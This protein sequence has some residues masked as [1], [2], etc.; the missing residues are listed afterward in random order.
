MLLRR[1]S[2][3]A[4]TWVNGVTPVSPV[5]IIV[6]LVATTS[7]LAIGSYLLLKSRAS[8]RKLKAE[9]ADQ[10][11]SAKAAEAANRAKAE[12]LTSMS[13]QIRTPLNAIM[14]FTDLAL[15]SELKPELRDYLDTVRL[16]ADWLLQVANDVL[17]YSRLE[18][19]TLH[20]ESL[21][22]SVSECA[23]SALKLVETAAK[24]KKLSISCSVDR[25]LPELVRGDPTRL[26]YVIFNLLDNAVKFTSRGSVLLSVVL[27]A[28]GDQD[29]TIRVA[30]NDTG[31]GV[32]AALHSSIFEPYQA[33]DANAP[34]Q[35]RGSGVGLAM[36][37]RIVELMGGTMNVQSQLGAG[38]RFEFTARLGKES[39][40]P[41]RV[42]EPV[43]PEEAPKQNE[44]P[45]QNKVNI[46]VADDNN[47]DRKLITKVL[48]SAGCSVKSA[49]DGKGAVDKV[50]SE[51][52]DLVL[53]D[54]E[55][56]ELDG[57]QATREIRAREN[58]SDRTP[59]FALTAHASPED[60]ARCLDAGMDDFISKPI[61]VDELL[62]LVSHLNRTS[63]PGTITDQQSSVATKDHDEDPVSVSEPREVPVASTQSAPASDTIVSSAGEHIDSLASFVDETNCEREEMETLQA[64]EPIASIAAPPAWVVEPPEPMPECEASRNTEDLEAI[65]RKLYRQSESGNPFARPARRLR[66]DEVSPAAV[67]HT[68]SSALL[69][70]SEAPV[71]LAEDTH[72]FAV[73]KST[74]T[75]EKHEFV[76]EP[77]SEIAPRADSDAALAEPSQSPLGS[78]SSQEADMA[79][80][81]VPTN[82]FVPQV[83]P[84]RTA[85]FQPG[86]V[87]F[88]EVQS[89]PAAVMV[90]AT[91][92]SPEPQTRLAGDWDPFEQARKA[93]FRSRFDV[94]VIHQDGDP[95]N[96]NLI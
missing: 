34:T 54:M 43:V 87:W 81:L 79:G 57:L 60:R 48:E 96:R 92:C 32:T 76:A 70:S 95:G 18:A 13:H 58:A 25:G 33:I 39:N 50:Q 10:A 6:G 22:F 68:D 11:T 82:P 62:K 59:I 94:R 47:L 64:D 78:G 14:G 40:I 61:Q 8:T 21:P 9:L 51:S 69:M 1:S 42:Q 74:E 75:I 53:M 93:L 30:V 29:L 45:K 49:S 36:A 91:V 44:G 12:F 72:D 88:Q 38:S 56:P 35:N 23:H 86:T 37:K 90:P 4:S 5:V 63:S 16:S 89:R 26:R 3:N 17:N 27:D 55:M 24:A 73:S 80:V 65:A 41:A 83:Q 85:A 46:L 28:E 31:M 66:S 2:D 19:G 77:E 71:T 15:R 67:A 20:L 7:F 84:R 52:F